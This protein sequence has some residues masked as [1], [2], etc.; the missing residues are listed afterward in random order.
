M[1]TDESKKGNMA[2]VFPYISKIG[3]VD[4]KQHI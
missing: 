4:Q 3:P 1:M 2:F